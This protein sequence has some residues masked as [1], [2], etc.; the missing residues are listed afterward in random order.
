LVV[1]TALESGRAPVDK[2]NGTL[3][4]DGSDGGV[5]VLGDNITTVHHAASHVLSV[6]RVTLSHH[7]GRLEHGVG[8]LS[9]GELL[10][11]GF[12][13][14]DDRSVRR[15][16][17]VD[18]RV[19]HQVGLELGD[20]NVES[21]I[22]TEGR[23]QR[24]NYLG[25]QTVQVG[26]GRALNVER[27]TANVVHS[28]VVKHDSNVSVLKERVSRQ[29]AVVR[30]NHGGGHL[31]S[32]VHG[33]AELGLL[34][35]VDGQTLKKERSQTGTSTTTDGVEHEESLETSAVI[36]ELTNAVKSHIYNF[37]ANGVVTK[38]VVVV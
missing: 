30:L 33:E 9:Y 4:L 1:D 7:G 12:L 2:L 18:T 10:V 28:L 17:K 32:R 27:T 22:E 3:G 11:V 36:R 15:Q 37:V 34:A 38:G 16:H 13:S 6:T 29:D 25:H 23:S 8:D 20:I 35:V 19:R 14:R 24:R 21:T 5:D 31:G 26:V